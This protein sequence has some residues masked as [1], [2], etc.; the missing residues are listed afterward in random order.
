MLNGNHTPIIAMDQPLFTIDKMIQL[1][2]PF[3]YHE[4]KFMIMFDGNKR[5]QQNCDPNC[6]YRCC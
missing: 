3:T 5:P 2:N 6:G 1:A 4:D